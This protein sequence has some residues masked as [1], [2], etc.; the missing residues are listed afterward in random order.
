MVRL[1]YFLINPNG[2]IF[3]E[4]ARLNLGGSFFAS[5]ADSLLFEGNA[6][7]SASNP[8]APPLLDVSIPI[9]LN[10]RDNPGDI[11][12][13]GN[14]QGQRQRFDNTLID[15]EE[16][17][18]VNSDA[19]LALV[20]GHINLE[21]AT[22]KTAGGRIELGS[23]DSNEQISLNAIDKGWSLG[24]EGVQNFRDIRLLDATNIDASGLVS[25]DI[26]VQGKNIIFTD[27]SEIVSNALSEE[28]EPINSD[29][30]IQREAGNIFVRAKSLNLDGEASKIRS[31]TSG[32]ENTGNISISTGS[33]ALRGSSV[34]ETRTDSQGNSGDIFI[35]ASSS[36]SVEG[37]SRISAG[38]LGFT[39]AFNEPIVT[40]NAG[41]ISIT[42]GS[43]N[44]SN[45]ATITSQNEGKGDGG[46]ISI[47]VINNG[48]FNLT[49]AQIISDT[50][51]EETGGDSGDISI[52]A[53]SITISSLSDFSVNTINT[54]TRGSGNAGNINLEATN[55]GTVNISNISIQTNSSGVGTAGDLAINAG[56]IFLENTI[57]NSQITEE[58]VNTLIFLSDSQGNTLAS[59]NNSSVTK[60]AEGSVNRLDSFL[61]FVFPEDG[62][63]IIQVS[64]ESFEIDNQNF[65]LQVSIENQ[66]ISGNNDVI[67]DRDRDAIF[68]DGISIIDDPVGFADAFNELNP[69]LSIFIFEGFF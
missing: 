17:L 54:Q 34:I 42:A 28:S 14:G 1:I 62:T 69:S 22:L 35:T 40:G 68:P 32:A 65:T 37:N 39:S 48:D 46:N 47:N 8:Q 26:Q 57:I 67:I 27:F 59:N 2:I 52:T 25:G 20:G 11:T 12:V 29:I 30:Q 33:I 43:V 38:S 10:F 4:N 24:F 31:E 55:N 61:E 41:N 3:G 36:F 56:E 21:G 60:G 58:L 51:L 53:G 16:A 23:V 45:S 19:T 18:R 66:D 63:Y 5:T 49:D 15:T 9:G 50:S 64:L 13:R 44:I 7:F 6:E